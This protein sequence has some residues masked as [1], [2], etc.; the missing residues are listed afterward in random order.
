[1][2]NI[3]TNSN[4]VN[5]ELTAM[6]TNRRTKKAGRVSTENKIFITLGIGVVIAILVNV[7]VYGIP[8][9]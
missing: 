8:Q 5:R 4:A 2:K 9:I 7:F 3:V 6:Q 1:M